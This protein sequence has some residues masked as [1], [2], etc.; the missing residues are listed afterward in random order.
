MEP[1]KEPS[2]FIRWSLIAGIVIV[3]NMFFNYAISL[4][5][6]E[7]EYDKIFSR[8]QVVEEIKTKEAC[9][10]VGGQWNEVL[11]PKTPEQTEPAT[12]YCDPDYTK[13]MQYDEARSLY[14]RNVFMLL[15]ALGAIAMGIGI[16]LKEKFEVV[17]IAFSWGGVLSFI[18]ASMRYWSDANNIFK[19]L[20]LGAALVALIYLA[21]RKFAK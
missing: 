3:L 7:P 15:V 12:G 21:V 13:R 19:V 11:Y 9:L 17:A 20:I 2:R 16:V 6:P 14:T 8:P 1:T 10:A 4:L 18:I 5:Y